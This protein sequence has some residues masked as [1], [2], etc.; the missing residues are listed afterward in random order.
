MTKD[1]IIA[2]YPNDSFNPV[3]CETFI[4]GV[5]G[6]EH[7]DLVSKL[8]DTWTPLIW[9]MDGVVEV[10]SINV[11][12]PVCAQACDWE[13][14]ESEPTMQKELYNR[15]KDSYSEEPLTYNQK[16]IQTI[17]DAQKDLG[18]CASMILKSASGVKTH[19]LN[20]PP[21]TLDVLFNLFASEPIED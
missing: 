11:V 20:I 17:I 9:I 14:P 13:D 19:E 2:E 3:N 5:C 6:M 15:L 12:C 16:Q 7:N 4:C 10:K 18:L 21:N 1:D 8:E